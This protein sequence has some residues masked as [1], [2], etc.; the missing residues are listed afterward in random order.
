MR[1]G[2]LHRA[3][4]VLILVQGLVLAAPIAGAC[5]LCDRGAPC[6]DMAAPTPAAE[7]HSCCD[8]AAAEASSAPAPSS[9]GFD[10]CDCGRE[11]PPAVTAAPSFAA[12][13]GA[14]CVVNDGIVSAGSTSW[15]SF[16]A[17][18]RHPAP[19]PSPLIFLIDCVFLT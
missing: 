4:A 1:Q 2:S 9:L 15:P 16:A 8:S 10:A 6:P 11:A 5:G 14:A 13:V 18:D 19:L 17:C 3:I 12:D 7:E